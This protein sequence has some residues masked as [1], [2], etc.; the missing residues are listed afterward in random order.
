MKK[1]KEETGNPFTAS[2]EER[3]NKLEEWIK[4]LEEKVTIQNETLKTV[5]NLVRNAVG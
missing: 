2:I 1:R 3:V 4:E 5:L